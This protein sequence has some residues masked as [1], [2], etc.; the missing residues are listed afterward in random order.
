MRVCGLLPAT[1]LFG[2]FVDPRNISTLSSPAHERQDRRT[3]AK[4]DHPSAPTT[5]WQGCE[6]RL[7]AADKCCA[8]D[9]GPS[10]SS[11]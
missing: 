9:A 8:F 11:G 6:F 7:G 2:F 10:S 1:P 4:R 3:I 5:G